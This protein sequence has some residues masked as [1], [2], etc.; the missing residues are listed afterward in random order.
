MNAR[1]THTMPDDLHERV[2]VLAEKYGTSVRGLINMTM[3]D[4]S[5]SEGLAAL[6]RRV[7]ELEK[8]LNELK[9]NKK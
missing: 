8:G 9:S 7:S 2:K 3:K 4:L 5:E 6:E 1:F